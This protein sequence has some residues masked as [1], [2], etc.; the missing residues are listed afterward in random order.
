[1][2]RAD[3][4]T[5]THAGSAAGLPVEDGLALD[6]ACDAFEAKWRAGGRPALHAAL[7]ELPERLR[8]TALLELIQLD[9]FYRKQAGEAVGA[10]DYADRF[11]GLDPDWLAGVAAGGDD[12]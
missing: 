11:P 5:G 3:E 2:S 10:A 9:V 6:R 8:P 7:L 12:T 1:M 4:P